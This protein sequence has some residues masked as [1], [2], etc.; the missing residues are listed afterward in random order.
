[1]DSYV[2]MTLT[3]ETEE[4]GEKP[5]PVSLS[6]PQIPREV[7]RVRTRVSPVSASKDANIILTFTY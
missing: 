4:F 7:N 5:V 3:G 2:R 1:M 6:P